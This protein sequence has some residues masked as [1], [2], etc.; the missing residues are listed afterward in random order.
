MTT[1][2]I[3]THINEYIK[4][5][6]IPETKVKRNIFTRQC[7]AFST[8]MMLEKIQTGKTNKTPGSKCSY[9][10]KFYCLH[11]LAEGT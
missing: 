9:T 1:T 3:I 11:S 4:A 10:R 5:T 6:R 2:V 8:G 7:N